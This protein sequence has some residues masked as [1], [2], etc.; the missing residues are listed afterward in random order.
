MEQLSEDSYLNNNNKAENDDT[1]MKKNNTPDKT[2]EDKPEKKSDHYNFNTKYLFF[3]FITIIFIFYLIN[4]SLFQQ[5]NAEINNSNKSA[6]TSTTNYINNLNKIENYLKHLTPKP[7]YNGPKFS[8]DEKIS[9]EWVLNL[10][11]YM[12]D[13]DN[14]KSY[15]EKYIDK[16]YLL[17]M[18][19]KAKEIFFEQKEAIVDITI[20][21][22][23]YIT[24][25]GDIH[26]QFYDL[27]NIFEINGYPS[28]ENPYLFNGDFVDRG[29]FG[30]E[31]IVTLIAFKILYPNHFFM[32]RGNH[33][34]ISINYRYGFRNEAIDKYEGDGSVF[35]CFS[36]LFKFLPLGHVL[37]K[38]VL[39]IH[40]GLFNKDG[41]TIDELKKIDRFINVP[42]KGLMADL[43]WSDPMEQNGKIPSI[44]G[45]GVNFGPDVT[46]KFLKENNLKLLVRSHQVRMEG[47]QIEQGGKVI[48]V[49]SAPNYCDRQGNKGAIIR[50]KGAEMNP[51][52]I[53]FEA[54]PH[55]DISILKYLQ[56]SI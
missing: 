13:P 48:T 19:K 5:N 28:E 39:V 40:G 55:P 14:K 2:K 33:E 10:I 24:V 47:Y 53:K 8:E 44:R 45:A 12:K 4:I 51:N 25:V 16:A 50:F 32:A 7:S 29:V 56:P 38:E 52:F 1:N 41:V 42:L 49:F 9:K 3:I 36:E 20:P 54:S 6:N 34:D 15:K 35:D 46:E 22:D 27:L 31:C 43:L 23:K 21:K 17:R 11:D 30:I 26:G 18:L 37:N